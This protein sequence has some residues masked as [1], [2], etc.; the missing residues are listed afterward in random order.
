MGLLGI[1]IPTIVFQFINFAILLF[2]LSKLLFKPLQRTIAERDAQV[3]GSLDNAARREAESYATQREIDRR[4]QEVEREAEA[5]ISQAQEE[6]RKDGQGII[7]EARAKAGE[8]IAEAKRDGERERVEAV[9]DNYEQT[10]D[11]IVD[12]ASG[13][14]RSVTVRQTHDDL[15]TNFAAYIWQRS[16]E[17]VAEYR[18]SLAE[19][20]PTVFVYT[21]VTL[22]DNQLT[23]IRDTL[24]SLADRR[25]EVEVQ[26]EPSLIA[27]LQ[28][29]IGDRVIDNSLRKQLDQVRAQVGEQLRQ[30]LGV[31]E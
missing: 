8:I 18:R 22:T 4:L 2:L 26:Q 3:E 25:V 19:R 11:T 15:V 23:I 24:S 13:I 30:Q 20:E 16:P 21:P 6:S 27:G 12:L 1:S 10:L 7:E 28:V 29:R 17:E 14:L 9:K 31:A 5:L